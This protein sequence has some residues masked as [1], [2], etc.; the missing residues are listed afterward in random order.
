MPRNGPRVVEER[1]YDKHGV[2]RNAFRNLGARENGE[3]I[4]FADA[5]YERV[6]LSLGALT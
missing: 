5:T 2:L 3:Y 4:P 1:P 6:R